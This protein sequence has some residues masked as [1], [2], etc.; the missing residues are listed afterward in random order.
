MAIF[1]LP[2]SSEFPKF[3]FNT[4]LDEETFIFSFRLNERMDRWIMSI[5][6]AV[7]TPLIMGIPVLLGTVFYDQFQ[8]PALPKGRLFPINLES[9]NTEAGSEDLGKSVFIYY[10]DEGD[11][12]ARIAEQFSGARLEEILENLE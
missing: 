3:R 1:K 12:E 9:A 10:M 8:N 5:F 2:V 6:D 7:E 11:L 4:E